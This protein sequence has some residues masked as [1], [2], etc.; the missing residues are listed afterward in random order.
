[1]KYLLFLILLMPQVAMAE[2]FIEEKNTVSGRFAILEENGSSAWLYLTPSSG[3]GIEKDAFV[4]S[5]IEPHKELDK[6]SI[7]DGNPPVL[8]EGVASDT[9][10]IKNVKKENISFS[11]SK[12]GE[13]VV[14]L[15]NGN[16][17]AMILESTKQSYSKALKKASFFGSPWD[18]ELYNKV[19]IK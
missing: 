10:V 16:P 19:F 17:I 12:N 8:I 14:V 11:W 3:K 18:Q 1:M 13:S 4:Y 2:I 15:F 9:A 7:E 5:P 6:K